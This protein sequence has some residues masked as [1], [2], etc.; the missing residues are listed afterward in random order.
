MKV[1]PIAVVIVVAV[2]LGFFGGA[3]LIGWVLSALLPS[4]EFDTA[5]IVAGLAQMTLI[6][7]LIQLL[8]L[9]LIVNLSY[10][11][12]S[13]FNGDDDDEYDDDEYDDDEYDDD[14]DD[15]DDENDYSG[16]GL[17]PFKPRRRHGKR[18]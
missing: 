14:D 18:P 5:L 2:Y 4:V 8:T 7:G 13:L 6:L 9:V 11:S 3:L 17:P 1:L 16:R 15:D 10:F 12:G